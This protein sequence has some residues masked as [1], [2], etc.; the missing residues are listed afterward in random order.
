MMR[1]ESRR[2]NWIGSSMEEVR[3][4]F[5]RVEVRSVDIE[6]INMVGVRTTIEC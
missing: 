5:D 3:R 2:S 6:E 1:M 4:W